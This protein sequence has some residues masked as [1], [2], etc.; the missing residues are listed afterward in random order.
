MVV[1]ELMNKSAYGTIGYIDSQESIDKVE[2][3]IKYNLDILEE[4]ENII[5][6]TNFNSSEW[7]KPYELM[8]REY[9]PK[10]ILITS[11]ENRGHNHGY[12]DLDN[13]LFDYCKENNIEWLCKSANDS[14]MTEDLLDKQIKDADFYYLNG[15]GIG[16]MVKYEFDNERIIDEDF[17]PQTNFYFINVSKTDYLN[18]KQYADETYKYI[19]SLPEYNGRIWE[20][21][22]GWSC[23]KFLADC[24]E[25]NNLKKEHLISKEKYISLLDLVKHYNIHDCSHKNILIEGVCHLHFPEQ[26]IIYI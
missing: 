24:I 22:E 4:Y 17:Y 23:E 13:L 19:K 9:F 2:Q 7:I 10:C 18:N 14:I 15:I 8:W 5:I 21:I 3:Y 11:P 1:R 25:R 6:A 16:G 12:V 26:N 20:Y